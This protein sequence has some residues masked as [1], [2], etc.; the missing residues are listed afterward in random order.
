MYLKHFTKAL[1]ELLT[2]SN[3]MGFF[4]LMSES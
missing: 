2:S 1:V 3:V 4:F